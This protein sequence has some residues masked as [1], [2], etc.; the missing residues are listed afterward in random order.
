MLLS[1][2]QGRQHVGPHEPKTLQVSYYSTIRP[3]MSARICTRTS[4]FS[5]QAQIAITAMGIHI[6]CTLAPLTYSVWASLTL[7]PTSEHE[8]SN[9]YFMIA[10]ITDVCQNYSR[11]T[12]GCLEILML[13]V[14]MTHA[15]L[16]L[17]IHD[18]FSARAE[19]CCCCPGSMKYYWRLRLNVVRLPDGFS[20]R[21]ARVYP[22]FPDDPDRLRSKCIFKGRGAFW[23]GFHAPVG[24]GP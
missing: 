23:V 4:T 3:C 21:N 12:W 22:E 18:L 17:L 16:G 13:L 5:T 2:A 6:W 20:R 11:F 7:N 15:H 1:W 8:V 14:K 24:M 9:R 10:I 19:R